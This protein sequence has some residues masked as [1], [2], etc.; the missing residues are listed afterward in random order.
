MDKTFW[1]KYYSNDIAGDNAIIQSPSSFAQFCS[2]Y[3]RKND[4]VVDLG[5]GNG[6]DTIYFSTCASK[7]YGVDISPSVADRF[8]NTDV[9]FKC[10]SIDDLENEPELADCN[11]AYSR[12]SIHS[13]SKKS[14]DTI[15]KWAADNEISQFFIETRSVN[16][17]RY[18]VGTQ[19]ENDPDAFIDTHYRRFTRLSELTSDL[20]N[21][22][23]FNILHAEEDFTSANYKSDL[24][25]VNRIICSI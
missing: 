16:D 21:I 5:C 11:I 23:G 14:Q 9:L 18:G 13:V 22:Y 20:K 12:F 6:R 25:V 17:P 4:K 15:F 19:C 7:S 10:K 2:K 8:H 1:N 24:A 3:I